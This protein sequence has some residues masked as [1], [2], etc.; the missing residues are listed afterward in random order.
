[1]NKIMFVC[2][3]N[4]CRSTMAEFLMKDLVEKKGESQNFLIASSGTSSEELGHGVHW[5]TRKILDRLNVNYHG[6]YAVKLKSSDYDNYDYFIGMDSDN[7]YMMN[8]ILGGDPQNKIK[9]LLSFAGKNTDVAD[10][11]WT[12]DFEKTY[13]DV[14]Q[15][16]SALYEFL[17]KKTVWKFY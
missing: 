11:Y 14:K 16:I 12:G 9:L 5:G 13:Q 8:K 6:K 15:G 17:T 4:I 7:L 10:P 3:G 1:M 2:Y